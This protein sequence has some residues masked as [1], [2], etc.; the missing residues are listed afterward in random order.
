MAFRAND[1]APY[2]CERYND[3]TTCEQTNEHEMVRA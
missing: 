3:K 1:Q 2:N